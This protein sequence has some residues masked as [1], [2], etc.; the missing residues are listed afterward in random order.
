MYPKFTSCYRVDIYKCIF[1]NIHVFCSWRV[2]FYADSNSTYKT[3]L[4]S[5]IERNTPLCNLTKVLQY[6][7][8]HHMHAFHLLYSACISFSIQQ[9]VMFVIGLTD[10]HMFDGVSNF[11]NRIFFTSIK[12]FFYIKKK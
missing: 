2:F 4:F 1:G 11:F 3:F 9:E 10:D 8:L 12:M 5:M 6:L 7:N